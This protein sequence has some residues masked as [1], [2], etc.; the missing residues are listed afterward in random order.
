MV[1]VGLVLSAVFVPCAFIGGITGQFF[2]QFALTIAASTVISTFNSLTL[3]P[4]LSAVLLRPRDRD[5]HEA[6]PRLAFP[7]S[8]VGWGTTGLRDRWRVVGTMLATASD[9]CGSRDLRRR[10]H[11]LPTAV[12]MAATGTIGWFVARPAAAILRAGFRWFN[13]GFASATNGYTRAVGGLLRVSVLVLFVYAGM[14]FATYR[15]FSVTPKGFIPAQ[16]M[17]HL[18]AAVQ[19]PDAASIERTR[20]AWTMRSELRWGCEASS[21]RWPLRDRHSALARRGRISARLS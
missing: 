20:A 9:G 11:G 10:I 8:A 1:A 17:G 21:I 2:R 16:D 5:T 15:C 3:S 19:L 4:A 6:L 18:Y 14:L 7:C 13:A 12:A